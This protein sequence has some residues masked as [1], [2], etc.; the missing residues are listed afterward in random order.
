LFFLSLAAAIIIIINID[1]INN[2]N[3]DTVISNLE[4]SMTND[5]VGFADDLTDDEVE[6]IIVVVNDPDA[7][8][9]S[10]ETN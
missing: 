7:T 6:S 4:V 2:I 3:F 9:V 10:G 5:G 1:D 8:G